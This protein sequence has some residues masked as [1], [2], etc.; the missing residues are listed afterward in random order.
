MAGHPRLRAP[1]HIMHAAQ[2]LSVLGP[3]DPNDRRPCQ[4]RS[5][6]ATT[7]IR[8]SSPGM[9]FCMHNNILRL[10]WRSDHEQNGR[11]SL[12]WRCRRLPPNFGPIHFFAVC[13]AAAPQPSPPR[14]MGP[15]IVGAS[16]AGTPISASARG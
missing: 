15:L 7:G 10:L 16:A 5:S 11:T 3:D 2:D 1:F 14:R 13:M 6:M 9:G 4:P 8:T 12:P